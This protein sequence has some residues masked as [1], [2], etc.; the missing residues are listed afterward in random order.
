VSFL[1]I[2]KLDQSF[3]FESHRPFICSSVLSFLSLTVSY[4][5]DIAYYS[6]PGLFFAYMWALAWCGFCSQLW[7]LWRYSSPSLS[8]TKMTLPT[9]LIQVYSMLVGELWPSAGVC[10]QWRY[11]SPSPSVTKTTFPTSLIQAY[12][13]LE[14]ELWPGVGSV[15]GCDG[16]STTLLL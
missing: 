6:N 1:W 9:T 2:H 4:K 7:W 8:L 10:W 5:D 12:S 3:I 11:S 14:G 16:S 13:M 15:P